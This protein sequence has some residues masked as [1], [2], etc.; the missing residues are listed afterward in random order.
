MVLEHLFP[1]D[2]LERKHRYAFLLAFLYSLVAIV[3]A[4]LLFG[5]NSGI[6]SVVFTSLLLI[7]YI[8]KLFEKG[9]DSEMQEPEFNLK[10]FWANNKQAVRI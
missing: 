5:A 3:V 8:K 4:R 7:P 10:R 2:W 1:D 6:V 9:R